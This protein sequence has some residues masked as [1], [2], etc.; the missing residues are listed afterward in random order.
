MSNVVH[1]SDSS[2]EADV[3]KSDVPVLVDFYAEWCGPCKALG[4]MIED[5]A[6]ELAGKAK[7]C[8]VDVDKCNQVATTYAITSVPTV[9]IF[10]GGKAVQTLVGMRTKSA[11]EA[12]L[13]VSSR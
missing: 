10:K 9:M 3:L 8:K 13:G 11:Y 6:K 4:P 7:I 1:L 2:F 5:L 12:A